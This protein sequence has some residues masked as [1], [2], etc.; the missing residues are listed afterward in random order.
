M[1]CLGKYIVYIKHY[2]CHVMFFKVVTE[3]DK[4]P[5]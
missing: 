2:I 3:G 1:N 4:V 5:S